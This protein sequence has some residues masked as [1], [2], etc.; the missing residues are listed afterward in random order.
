MHQWTE[1]QGEKK[2]KNGKGD[3]KRKQYWDVQGR[4]W[5]WGSFMTHTPFRPATGTC[6]I[7]Y[8]LFYFIF[9]SVPVFVLV[10]ES[11]YVE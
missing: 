1:E 2:Q 5:E 9:Y 11:H 4:G 10:R 7:A 3:K 8:F 6:I